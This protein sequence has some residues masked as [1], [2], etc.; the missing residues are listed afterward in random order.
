MTERASAS[1]AKAASPGA[2]PQHRRRTRCRPQSGWCRASPAPSAGRTDRGRDA[3]ELDRKR[4]ALT[5]L[6]ADEFPYIREL[7]EDMLHCDDMPAYY[8]FGIDVFVAGV[9]SMLARC[10]SPPAADRRGDRHNQAHEPTSRQS[11]RPA[12]QAARGPG[13]RA[14][15]RRERPGHGRRRRTRRPRPR[16]PPWPRARWP[17][18]APSRPTPTPAPA[19]T[20]AWM[21]CAARGGRARSG[22]VGPRAEP[23]V[24]AG[25][26]RPGPGGCRHRRGGRGRPL[27]PAPGR[28]RPGSRRRT[29]L[30]RFA[31]FSAAKRASQRH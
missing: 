29:R 23:R 16:G 6:P 2:E 8:A 1:C 7:A 24:L 5:Q 31:P 3:S 10:C 9:R 30:T 20:A 17:A 19:T 12:H 14:A 13:R 4:A 11:A 28:Q 22:P 27:Q 18:G 15:G 26:A 21:R 25:A